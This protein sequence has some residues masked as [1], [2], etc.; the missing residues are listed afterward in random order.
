MPEHQS[1][2]LTCQLDDQSL[3]I[4]ALTWGD[5][6]SDKRV[7]CAHGLTRNATDFES[8]AQALASDAYVVAIDFPGRGKSDWLEEKMGY[9]VPSYCQLAL[10]VIQQCQLGQ[11][12]WLGTSMGGLIGMGLAA[13]PNSPIQSLLLNDVGPELNAPAIERI[14]QYLA[15]PLTFDTREALAAHQRQIYAPFGNLSV[16]QWQHITDNDWRETEE[17]QFAANYDPGIAIAV[18]AAAQEPTPDLWPLWQAL[19]CNTWLLRGQH[20]D[21]LSVEVAEKMTQCGPQARLVTIENA[22]HAP[23]LMDEDQLAI[24]RRWLD[25]SA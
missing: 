17:Q 24:V 6:T 10:Q 19:S 2:Y 11:V 14:C 9:N 18:L 13:L 4:H 5:P 23:A 15:N 8:V 25:H 3:N 21:L 7:V 12:H 16:A 22:G 1:L 20:S